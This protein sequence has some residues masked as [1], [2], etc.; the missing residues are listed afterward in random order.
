MSSLPQLSLRGFAS[1]AWAAIC[2]CV[3]LALGPV[4]RT[5]AAEDASPAAPP[6]VWKDLFEA[7][8]CQ[9]PVERLRSIRA[10]PPAGATDRE[11]RAYALGIEGVVLFNLGFV[12][13]AL[14]CLN[15]AVEMAPTMGALYAARVVVRPSEER[16]AIEQDYQTLEKLHAESIESQ[17]RRGLAK[18]NWGDESGWTILEGVRHENPSSDS[19]SLI[20]AVAESSR[21]A[22]DKALSLLR[23]VTR[24]RPDN[25]WARHNLA[26][27][28]ESIGDAAY[29]KEWERYLAQ[30][31]GCPAAI[32]AY[33]DA[34]RKRGSTTQ[35]LVQV[36]AGFAAIAAIKAQGPNVYTPALFALRG[37]LHAEKRE[38]QAAFADLDEAERRSHGSAATG[39]K[40]TKARLYRYF[41]DEANAL[42]ELDR[43]LEADPQARDA[44]YERA[45]LHYA[46]KSY[47][48]A[49]AD[50][51]AI[52][53]KWA[54]PSSCDALWIRA[55]SC[56][57]LGRMTEAARDV[58]Y[59]IRACHLAGYRGP[60]E[61]ELRTQA[62]A[63]YYA[64]KNYEA[65]AE[66]YE[67][68]AKM[69]SGPD[70]VIN[71]YYHAQC[72]SLL[73]RH[74]QALEEVDGCLA[75]WPGM[76][77]ALELRAATCINLKQFDRALSDANFVI[78]HQATAQAY[79]FRSI[80]HFNLGAKQ[81]AVDD[82]AQ[83]RAR[84]PNDARFPEWQKQLQADRETPEWAQFAAGLLALAMVA[85]PH[86][87]HRAPD[88]DGSPS[89]Y[90][91][92][93][94][95][96]QTRVV[97]CPHCHGTGHEMNISLSEPDEVCMECG[98]VGT[99]LGSGD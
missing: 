97:V 74:R 79:Y 70:A 58:G 86:H 81:A 63:F 14:T 57:A 32:Y 8:A 15:Q 72:L 62:A 37:L 3:G 9:S 17:A 29:V 94:A 71:H 45:S 52:D 59:M 75:A 34:L 24:R 22:T 82:I 23:E 21:G 65:A 80:A 33:A 48:E 44:W 84:D 1:L 76:T 4:T 35:A 51:T 27:A 64:L 2:C 54:G 36:E 50:C 83:A 31:P 96:S 5:V 30:A 95:Q 53:D 60:K 19:V 25:L 38:K 90:E 85:A 46:R 93:L 91:R 12:D 87:A 18:V 66:N 92:S 73:G 20:F 99:V 61:L 49:I 67:A 55:W 7:T 28:M 69:T 68:L 56:Y 13:D 78:N 47:A 26:I 16:E 42:R 88:S 11:H 6:R 39:I 89:E 40:L 43:L 10:R 41:D 77:E 98:G